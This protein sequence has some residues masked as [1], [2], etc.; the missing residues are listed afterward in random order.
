MKII[1]DL[2]NI[3]D[4]YD[5]IIHLDQ[6]IKYIEFFSKSKQADKTFIPIIDEIIKIY[7]QQNNP[8]MLPKIEK[9]REIKISINNPSSKSISPVRSFSRL[10]NRLL[11]EN[12][13]I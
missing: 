6:L 13:W 3:S 10:G 2:Y 7:E 9:L 12:Y 8:N 5:K 4:D 1:F 11:L